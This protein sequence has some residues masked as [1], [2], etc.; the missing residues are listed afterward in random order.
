[1]A[2]H[3]V[4]PLWV[5]YLLANPLRKLW[6]PPA[7]LLRPFVT[8]GMTVL[9]VGCALG[10]FS[11]PLA[12]L[13]GPTG[14]VVCVDRQA[15]MIRRL[16]KRARRAGVADVV[17]ARVCA[18]DSLGLDDYVGRIEFALAA[19]VVHE[20]PDGAALFRELHALLIPRGRVL[21]AEPA[22][23]VTAAA[24]DVT[25]AQAAA[26]GFEH[27]DPPSIRRCRSG[28]MVKP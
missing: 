8:E 2:E 13:A 24:F 10:F 21:V 23:H 26:A 14:R 5:G 12:R 7:K 25:L 16:E 3:D 28:L 1:M 18:P 22:D 19:A 27:L 11:L 20:V 17:A 9:D 6:H 15:R 4:C